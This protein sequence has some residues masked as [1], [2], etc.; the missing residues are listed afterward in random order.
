M[1][2]TP[3]AQKW[4]TNTWYP[5]TCGNRQCAIYTRFDTLAGPRVVEIVGFEA[6]CGD[7][8]HPDLVPGRIRNFDGEWMDSAAHQAWESAFYSYVVVH[9]A[10]DAGRPDAPRV[11]QKQL[12]RMAGKL[13]D[14]VDLGVVLSDAEWNGLLTIESD[15]GPV[16]PRGQIVTLPQPAIDAVTT[17]GVW[18][19][20][21][22]R[23]M[24]RA[25]AEARAEFGDPEAEVRWWFEGQ[26]GSR[27][28]HLDTRGGLSQ[29]QRRRVTDA[30]ELSFGGAGR[31]V[32]EG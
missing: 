3:P 15:A 16:K 18:N 29:A 31:L 25:R 30:V 1:T 32:W 5:D 14:L 11:A 10:E 26:G 8:A 19:R 28:L 17:V 22:N 27:V 7:H 13:A 24:N 23:L 6:V 12:E 2:W 9:E 21:D 4:K 20:T